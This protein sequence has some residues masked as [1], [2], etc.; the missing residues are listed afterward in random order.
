MTLLAPN[1]GFA[2][3][4]FSGGLVVKTCGIMRVDHAVAAAE[5][6]AS[7]IGLIFAQSRRRITVEMACAVKQ[8]IDG[9]KHRPLLVGVFV[10][11]SAPTIVDIAERIGLDVIQ[12]SGDETPIEVAECARYYPVLKALRFPVGTEVQTALADFGRYRDLV[13]VGRLRFLVDTFHEG[14]YGGTGRLADWGIAA[15]LA[16]HES[17]MLAGGLTHQN[18]AQAV[19]EVGPWGVDV[20]SGIEH[21]GTKDQVLIRAFVTSARQSAGQSHEE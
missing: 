8:A 12:L 21:D 20:S 6:G 11:E 19:G 7:M 9:L 13:P 15:E 5:A 1:R 16:C 4:E 3:I 14:E 18:V 2:A 10:N 17:I